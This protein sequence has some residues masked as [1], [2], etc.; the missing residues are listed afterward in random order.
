MGRR[1]IETGVLSFCGIK[2]LPNLKNAPPW[3][4]GLREAWRVLLVQRYRFFSDRPNIVIKCLFESTFL[5]LFCSF[6]LKLVLELH[7]Q[8]GVFGVLR[9]PFGV[10]NCNFVHFLMGIV[11]NNH[12]I[13]YHNEEFIIV[14]VGSGCAGADGM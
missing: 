1:L 2:A 6:F 13:N 4:A 11:P 7:P 10:G 14:C 8:R 12:Q 9:R 3:F 5:R